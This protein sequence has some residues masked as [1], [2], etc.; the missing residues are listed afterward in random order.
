MYVEATWRRHGQGDAIRRYGPYYAKVETVNGRRVRHYLSRRVAPVVV[1]LEQVRQARASADRQAWRE[2]RRSLSGNRRGRPF[3]LLPAVRQVL[4]AA[5]YTVRG[6]RIAS[7]RGAED[8]P[9]AMSV[10]FALLDPDWQQRVGSAERLGELLRRSRRLLCGRN[11]HRQ[12]GRTLAGVLEDLLNS[13]ADE[14][15]L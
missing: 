9:M 5:G 3:A 11:W 7:R 2:A 10:R 12:P 6:R 13:D 8:D 14:N 15:G 4:L 1:Q